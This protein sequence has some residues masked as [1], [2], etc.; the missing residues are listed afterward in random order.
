MI[1]ISLCMI[2][3]NEE[4]TLSRALESVKDVVDEI[5]IIDTGSVD[6]TKEIAG[7]FTSK[8]Y[9]FQWIDDFSAARNYSFSKA[10]MDY[11]MWLDADDVVMEED[12]LKIQQLKENLDPA[13]DIV[14]AKY[15]CG[16]DKEGNITLSYF[17]S[18][19]LKRSKN[20]IWNE[21][22][23]EYIQPSGHIINSDICITHKKLHPAL[24]KRNL[25]IFE[26]TIASGKEL[27]PR[28]LFYYAREL[29]YNKRYDDAIKNFNKY[30]DIKE[31]WVEDKISACYDLAICYSLTKE[32]EKRLKT[33][34]KSFEFSTPRA[35]ICCQIGNHYLEA[36]DYEK[37]IGWYKLVTQLNKP[38]DTWGFILHDCWGYIPNM[39]LCLCYDR[40]GNI[41]EAIRYNN[42][43]AQYKPNDEAVLY[44]IKYFKG[45]K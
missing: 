6:K 42:K 5:I 9:D 41:E 7:K 2:V 32:T 24:P 37:A 28:G 18:R 22:I 14:M 26:K 1:T 23:H 45:I 29:Y 34:F 39:Q 12:G 44:N 31:G 21:P 20:F 33:L 8:I 19:I 4:D 27:S 17:R 13:V 15:N 30:L 3:K 43:A 16:F 38:V 36:E 10:T 35:E 40:L 11:I 25:D